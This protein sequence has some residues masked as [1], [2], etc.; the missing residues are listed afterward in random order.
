MASEDTRKRKAVVWQSTCE[1]NDSFSGSF[2]IAVKNADWRLGYSVQYIYYYIDIMVEDFRW[3]RP[4]CCLFQVSHDSEVTSELARMFYYLFNYY[5]YA[6]S[7]SLYPHYC[8]KKSHG[9]N[10]NGKRWKS[11]QIMHNKAGVFPPLFCWLNRMSDEG[12][13]ELWVLF[14]LL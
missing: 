9:V 10:G 5:Y 14:G 2:P 11:K 13:F 7:H 12:D 3:C 8:W 1:T 4:K 6:C